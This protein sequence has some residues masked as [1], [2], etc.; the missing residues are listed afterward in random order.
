VQVEGCEPAIVHVD[1]I[2]DRLVD[3]RAELRPL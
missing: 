3:A 2:A 1:V